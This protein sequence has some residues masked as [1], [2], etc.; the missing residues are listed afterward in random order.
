MNKYKIQLKTN[1]NKDII[2]NAN[3]EQEAFEFIEKAFLNTNLVDFSNKDIEEV[4][5]KILERNDN[6]IEDETEENDTNSYEELEEIIDET[7]EKIR[8]EIPEEDRK[9][10]CPKCGCSILVDDVIEDFM[11]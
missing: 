1:L 6:K 8:T 5:V 4:S 11:S 10:Y 7:L 3:N 2:I 9:F